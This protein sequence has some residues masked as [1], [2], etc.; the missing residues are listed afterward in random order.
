LTE[1]SL[2]LAPAIRVPSGE[3]AME[4]MVALAIFRSNEPSAALRSFTPWISLLTDQL[5]V[6][7]QFRVL[8]FRR[9]AGLSD[10]HS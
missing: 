1:R 7:R 6:G 2:G 9:K 3:K 5:V 4:T 8:H 10:R